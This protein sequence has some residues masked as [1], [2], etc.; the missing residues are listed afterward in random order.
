MNPIRIVL[1]DDHCL[2]LEA[3]KKFL[4]PQFQVVATF[5][6]GYALVK[7]APSLKPDVIILDIGMPLMNG[8]NA[9]RRLKKLLPD[10]KLIYLTMSMDRDVAAEAFRFGTSG[11]VVKSSAGTELVEAIHEVLKNKIYI[12][13]LITNGTVGS[14]VENIEQR[15]RSTDKLTLRQKEVL[16][17]LVEGRSMKEVAFMLNVSPRIVAFHKYTMMENLRL[18]TSAE[19]IRCAVRDSLVAF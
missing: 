9:G 7:A 3:L 5:N 8:L 14:F 16:Q 4:E 6:D 17:L 19:L 1:A 18:K 2:F 13:P 12:T 15:K 10:T 11:Y